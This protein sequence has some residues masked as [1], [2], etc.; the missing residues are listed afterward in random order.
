[1]PAPD[2]AARFRRCHCTR[3]PAAELFL[4]ACRPPVSVTPLCGG[5]VAASGKTRDRLRPIRR[6][7]FNFCT[8]GRPR[9]HEGGNESARSQHFAKKQGPESGPCFHSL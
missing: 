3:P 2:A 8:R 5:Y 9:E 6:L 7:S 4:L 1:M